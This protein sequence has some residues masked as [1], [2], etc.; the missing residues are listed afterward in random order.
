MS[1]LKRSVKVPTVWSIRHATGKPENQLLSK[2]SALKLRKKVFLQPLF[3]KL[4]HSLSQIMKISSSMRNPSHFFSSVEWL[5]SLSVHITNLLLNLSTLH[6]YFL[7]L[8]YFFRLMDIIHQGSDLY[9]V[10]EYQQYDLKKQMDLMKEK[11]IQCFN[12]STVKVCLLFLLQVIFELFS[13]LYFIVIP[14]FL[15]YISITYFSQSIFLF[16]YFY[17][18]SSPSFLFLFL[19]VFP[20]FPHHLL[21]ISFSFIL[22]L[23]QSYTKQLLKGMLYCHTHRMMHRDLKPQNL[24][25]D[26]KGNLKIADFGLARM[27]S[28]PM[29]SY[30][31]EV[32]TLF[33]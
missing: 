1:E 10:F 14:I 15:S 13:L 8:F 11:G 3:G 12:P 25:V 29:R 2:R 32:V 31:H 7:F 17:S 26:M 24:L 33:V 28:I 18:S 21:F 4:L 9:L 30:T 16:S 27:Y 22:S 20:S 5:Y 19:S 23:P 6:F